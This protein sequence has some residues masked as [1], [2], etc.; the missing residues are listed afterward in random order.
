MKLSINSRML[1]SAGII[2][3]AFLGVT[4]V[5]LDNSFRISTEE[6]MRER[7]LSL[8]NVLIAS[9][10]EDE[11]GRMRITY[12]LPEARFFIPGSGLYAEIIKNNGETIWVSP[13]ISGFTIP[14][15]AGLDRG[16]SR[17]DY[18]Y[19]SDGVP[20]LVY[21]LGLTWGERVDKESGYTFFVIESLERQYEQVAAFRRDLWTWLGGV[22][23]LLLVMMALI[24]RWGLTPLRQVAEDLS[25][26]ESGNQ[27]ELRG[28]Y[29]RE[30]R[31]LTDN[32]NAMIR[33]NQEHEQRYKGSLGD[34][35]HSLKTPLAV[36]HGAVE[37]SSLDVFA[38][39]QTVKEQVARMDQIVQYQLQRAAAS[40][41]R[42]M[43]AP[44]DM[45]GMVRKVTGALAKVY[46]DKGVR[47]SFTMAEGLELHADEGDMMELLGNLVDNAYKWSR[48]RVDIQ[49]CAGKMSDGQAALVLSVS[50]DGPGIPEKQVGQVLKRG[51]RADQQV[52]GHGL[53]LAMVSEVV[54]IYSG[55]L[56][57]VPSVLGG[58]GINAKFPL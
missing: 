41:R 11:T 2:L 47:C 39:R 7:M 53:G 19:T 18:L 32:L 52:S 13:S 38:L 34:L 23:G 21:A 58:A 30:L 57:I 42:A 14:V 29:P 31:G 40:G 3:A 33:T 25:S 12:A 20:V 35:A 22:G 44:L 45:R 55:E 15:R 56:E 9:A 6:A 43:T 50:D 10:D 4:G 54:K 37:Q 51:V 49:I 27:Y 5:T 24:L 16:E 8:T 46:A 36:L 48:S 1:I 26:V 28:E 17:Y